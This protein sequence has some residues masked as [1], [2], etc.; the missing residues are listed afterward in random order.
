MLS[1]RLTTLTL[2]SLLGLYAC[3]GDDQTSSESAPINQENA[4]FTIFSPATSEVPIPS[5]LQFASETAGDGTMFAGTDPTNPV[6]TGIDSLDGNSVLSPIDIAF[7]GSLDDTQTLD[8]ASFIVS[9][10]NIIPNPNQNVFLLPLTYPSGD[11]LNPSGLEVP[12]FAEAL[13]FQTAAGTLALVPDDAASIATLTALATP[14]ARAEII[15][16]DG[17]TNNVIRINPIQ[18]LQPKTKYLVV[19]TGVNDASGNPVQ[20]STAYQ[21]LKDPDSNLDQFDNASLLSIREAIIGWET[22]AAG[23]FGFVQAVTGSGPS[24]SDIIFTLTFTTGGT[25]DVLN[26]LSAPESFFEDSLSSGYKLDAIG[27]LVSGQYLLDGTTNI[28]SPSANDATIAGTISA[29]LTST[30]VPG[31]TIPNALY[32]ESIATAIGAGADY[33]TI[34]ADA[35][36]AYLMQRAAAESAI[37][38]NDGDGTTIA[39]EGLLQVQ[40]IA[41]GAGAAVSDVFQVPTARTTNFFRQD[42]A[43]TLNEILIAPA[44]VYQGEIT[45]PYYQNV[46][47]TEAPTIVQTSNWVANATIGAVIDAGSGNEAGTTPPSDKIT[48]RYPFPTKQA[49]LTVPLLVTTPDETVLGLAGITKP[50][51]GWPVI[52]FVH[53]ITGDRST[54]LPMSTAL[55]S[56]CI[57]TDP[58]SGLPVA[59]GLPCYATIA[60]DQ[61]LHGVAPSGS[62]VSGLSSTSDPNFSIE[63]NIGDN[64][65]SENLGERH[66]NVTANEAATAVAMTYDPD[67]GSSGSLFVNLTNFANVRDNQRQMALDLLNLNA[68]IATI[69]LDDDGATTELD[70]G[71]VYFIGHSLGGI[72]GLPFVAVNNYAATQN[73]TLS[74]Q[75][76][77]KAASGLTA[78]GGVIRLLTNSTSFAPSI[79]QGLAAASNSLVQGNSGLESYMNVFQGILDSADIT[80]FAGS[81]SDQNSS[82]GILMI[83]VDNDLTIPNSA[84]EIWG[85]EPLSL[86]VPETGFV[87]DQ[88]PAPLAATEPLNAEFGTVKTGSVEASDGDA[89]VLVTRFTEGTHGTPVTADNIA[90]FTEMIT[91]IATFFAL[92]GDVSSSIV[93]N[94]AI[95]EE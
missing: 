48:Y 72:T 29:L 70:A 1:Y 30:T 95:V 82:T 41:A 55:A 80:N 56:A 10:T 18:P 73:S 87:I 20:A 58:D 62:L 88:F 26:Y 69:D 11:G 54:S 66:F 35:S 86:T 12:T 2:A 83:Q 43:S 49:D 81:L 3:G 84:D 40:G 32:N 71:N 89:A 25:T 15:S 68:S 85:G 39:A 24:A 27:K 7:S 52:I 76:M 45:I 60:I 37:S 53:G 77:V 75:P 63:S 46:P 57:T 94:S 9:G 36:A 19:I 91:Q 22:L 42:A 28:D 13:A 50:A 21:F 23:Y 61:P 34:A 38:V 65:P 90:V 78:G 74:Q 93:T 31:T 8:A 67:F 79:L 5:D 17:G 64:V 4:T 16:L 51:E 59:T 33:A 92:D 47:T 6:I 14:T 44:Q